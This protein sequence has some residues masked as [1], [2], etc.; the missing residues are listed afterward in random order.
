MDTVNTNEDVLTFTQRERGC[1]Y[2]IYSYAYDGDRRCVYEGN[3]GNTLE[4][5]RKA[6]GQLTRPTLDMYIWDGDCEHPDAKE[7]E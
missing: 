3:G 7:V 2:I 5:A 1:R 4:E 6:A